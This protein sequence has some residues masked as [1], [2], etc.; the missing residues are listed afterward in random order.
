MINYFLYIASLRRYDDMKGRN[1]FLKSIIGKFFITCLSR[2]TI[3]A[4]FFLCTV[5]NQ[6]GRNP[7]LNAGCYGIL[8]SVQDNPDSALETLDFSVS[9]TS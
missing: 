3:F 7:I 2:T 9:H 8:K 1:I 4:V 5:C 6:I